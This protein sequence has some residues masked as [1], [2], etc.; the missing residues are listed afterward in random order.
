MQNARHRWL[1]ELPELAEYKACV[2]AEQKKWEEQQE[3]SVAKRV[4][5]L[6][7]RSFRRASLL[8][9]S[10]I[11]VKNYTY[12]VVEGLDVMIHV[13]HSSGLG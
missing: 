8:T 12:S 3:I 4:R 6:P 13:M 9:S 7:E 2:R 5:A 10:L 11:S 1:E